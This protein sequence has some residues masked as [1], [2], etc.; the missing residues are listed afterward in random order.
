MEKIPVAQLSGQTIEHLIAFDDS[1]IL[2]HRAI[3]K[4]LRELISKAA[5]AG[6]QLRVASGFRS[7]QRQLAIWNEKVSGTRQVVNETGTPVT[8]DTLSDTAKLR[9]IL[10]WSALPG[11]SRHHWGTDLDIWDSAA[12]PSSYRLQLTSWEYS[13][14][15]PFAKLEK[16]LTDNLT[17]SSDF[18]RPYREDNGGVAPEPWHLSY[19]PVAQHYQ[20]QMNVDTLRNILATADIALKETVSKHLEEIFARYVLC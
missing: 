13:R 19:R 6:I 4:P 10:R 14:E 8:L 15:G 2:V 18:F 16:W 20:Q 12:V 3:A 9:A 1:G 5:D 7:F 11:A 17:E